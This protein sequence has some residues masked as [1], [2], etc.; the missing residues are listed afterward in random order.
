MAAFTASRFDWS[1][2]SLTVAVISPIE[3]LCSLNRTMLAPMVSI[4]S[5]IFSITRVV[6]R[7]ETLPAWAVDSVSRALSAIWR[8][9]SLDWWAV[10][11][12]SSI[13]VVVWLT[14]LAVSV[15]L[16][17]NWLAEAKISLAAEARTPAAL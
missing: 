15:E 14:A 8:A 16:V 2:R 11:F 1:A 10:C 9:R 12:T 6:C 3:A 7:T 17:A 5:R 13:V 4:C